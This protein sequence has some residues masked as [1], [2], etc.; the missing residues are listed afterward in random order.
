MTNRQI[1]SKTLSFSLI[2]VVWDFLAFIILGALTVLGFVIAEKTMDMGLI[3]LFIGF[4]IGLILVAF[5]L[6]FV[7][8]NFK[9]G[10]IAMMTK[11]IVEGKLPDNVLQEGKAVVK[12]RFLTVAAFFA[13]TKAIQGIFSEIGNAITRVGKAVGGDTGQ[14]IGA[15]ISFIIQVIVAYLSDCCLGWVFYRED[16]KPVRATLEGAVLFFKHGKTFFKNMGRV[17][18]LGLLSFLLIGGLFSGGFLLLFV[19]FSDSFAVLSAE[20]T[21]A[22]ARASV[23]L[24]AFFSNPDTFLFVCAIAA[25]I[26]LWSILH[27]VFVR[28]FIL[29]GVLRNYLEAG[30]K[31]IP[32]ES[33]FAALDS[34]S[35]KF[36]KLH[37][38]LYA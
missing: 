3:G 33:S 31:D 5:M 36:A 29:T 18:G 9:A 19:R 23:D 30:M 28:P 22:A 8:Y 34:K 32:A 14:S 26:I 1:Y 7:S 12:R 16:Q 38:E 10:Q 17:F 4:I 21:E 20:I 35:K 13:V 15:A 2:R 6:R 27:S 37:R 11:G 25:G 24:P